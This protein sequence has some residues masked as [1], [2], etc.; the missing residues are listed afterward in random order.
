MEAQGKAPSAAIGACYA[1]PWVVSAGIPIGNYPRWKRQMA[2]GLALHPRSP[3]QAAAAP[4]V[5][6]GWAWW[7][8]R[9]CDDKRVLLGVSIDKLIYGFGIDG[10]VRQC[11]LLARRSPRRCC[12]R[13]PDVGARFRFVDTWAAE[14]R[15]R[16]DDDTARHHA[17]CDH[18]DLGQP[19]VFDG[20]GA[21]PVRRPDHGRCRSRPVAAGRRGRARG[22]RRCSPACSRWRPSTSYS[23]KEA[24]WQSWTCS[25]YLLLGFTLFRCGRQIFRE[26]VFRIRTLVERG[27]RPAALMHA[28]RAQGLIPIFSLIAPSSVSSQMPIR[29]PF[30]TCN[31]WLA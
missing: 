20:A 1:R 19:L 30:F 10:W 23:M 28:A 5:V 14:R 22:C 24:N 8:L 25:I 15:T 26:Q 9:C 21:I 4:A 12:R 31:C 17:D 16:P 11:A 3:Q 29:T 13:T 27:F 18:A 6:A 2:G 7:R